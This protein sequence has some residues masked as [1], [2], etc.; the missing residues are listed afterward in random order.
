MGGPVN[1]ATAYML[2]KTERYTGI[3]FSGTAE[4]IMIM[5]P[6]YR[7]AALIP[8]TMRPRMNT[9]EDGAVAHRIEPTSKI[10]IA[11]TKIGLTP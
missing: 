1:E 7:A 5:P 10:N 3:R 8:A 2:D 4:R 6:A 9:P 11:V